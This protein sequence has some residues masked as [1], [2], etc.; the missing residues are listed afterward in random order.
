MGVE[1]KLMYII[2]SCESKVDPSK[3]IHR[4]L[5]GASCVP[6]SALDIALDILRPQPSQQIKVEH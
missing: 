2:E 4:V 3:D 6:V 5:G 1:A